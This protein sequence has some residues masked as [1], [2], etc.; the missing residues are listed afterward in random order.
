MERTLNV[1]ESVWAKKGLQ[2][3]KKRDMFISDN[4]QYIQPVQDFLLANYDNR[5]LGIGGKSLWRSRTIN[6]NSKKSSGEVRFSEN[7]KQFLLQVA[8]NLAPY[9]TGNLRSNIELEITNDQQVV[10]RYNTK[11]TAD[12]TR[13]LDNGYPNAKWKGFIAFTRKVIKNLVASY[14][15]GELS[16]EEILLYGRGGEFKGNSFVRATTQFV[17][18]TKITGWEQERIRKINLGKLPNEITP[19]MVAMADVEFGRRATPSQIRLKRDY[20]ARMETAK[21]TGKTKVRGE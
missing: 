6:V 17:D 10:I 18:T 15:A 20:L 2:S 1:V 11:G 3:Q 9:R 5:V 7:F 21:S 8:R 14:L 19:S 4:E 13:F 16:E 12:Y